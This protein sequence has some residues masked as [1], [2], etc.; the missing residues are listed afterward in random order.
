MSH[1]V[2]D[3][4][5]IVSGL[6]SLDWRVLQAV[7]RDTYT[8]TTRVLR[9]AVG[10]DVPSLE[11]YLTRDRWVDVNTPGGNHVSDVV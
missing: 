10:E 6:T 3:L 9:A 7:P 11:P 5:D 4:P 2:A 8:K 1:A